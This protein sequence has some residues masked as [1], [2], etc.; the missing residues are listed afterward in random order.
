M[1][2]TERNVSLRIHWLP[3]YYDNSIIKEIFSDFEKV[4]SIDDLKTAHENRV[5]LDG[6]RQVVLKTD[7]LLKQQIPHI[8]NFKS[9]NKVLVTMPG[10]PPYCLKCKG[11]GHTRVQNLCSGYTRG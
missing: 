7:E 8:I 11:I 2:I 6:T 3:T 4:L 10:R 9:G 5:T 1:S